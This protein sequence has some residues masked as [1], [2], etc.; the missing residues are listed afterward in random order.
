MIPLE[1]EEEEEEEQHATASAMELEQRANLLDQVVNLARDLGRSHRLR[2]KQIAVR[3]CCVYH[4][5]V[6]VCSGEMPEGLVEEILETTEDMDTE[7]AELLEEA[8]A[9]GVDTSMS[10]ESFGG[11]H[12][13]HEGE[14]EGESDEDQ[15]MD[16]D[17]DEIT[18]D[19]DEILDEDGYNS[20]GEEVGGGVNVRGWSQACRVCAG[21]G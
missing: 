17:D 11:S 19:E 5:C 10:D 6:C 14:G 15:V 8:H 12:H 18:D 4:V 7:I 1:E 3:L 13:S 21:G 16:S 20:A 9:G 2:G